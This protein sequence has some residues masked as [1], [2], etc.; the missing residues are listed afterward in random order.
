MSVLK[1]CLL[2]GTVISDN[3]DISIMTSTITIY[4]DGACKGNGQD[5]A[6]GGWAAVLDNGKKQ[7]QL[8][9]GVSD[10]TNQRME[11][12]AAIEGLKAV[13]NSDATIKLLTDS[14]YLQKGCNEWL[15]AWKAK[16]WKRSNGKPVLN[17]DLWQELDSL[18][19]VLKVT[20]QWVKGH[21]GNKMNDLADRLAVEAV[22]NG[23]KKN[24]EKV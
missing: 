24:Y 19:E 14:K 5:N 20:F 2:V 17:L 12:Q 13:R 6:Q 16:D 18:L 11:L 4:T 8:S 23:L 22:G 3:E 15:S 1:V 21:S 7:L 10:T 9:A